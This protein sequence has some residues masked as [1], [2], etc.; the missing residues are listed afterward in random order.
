MKEK[1]KNLDRGIL[2]MLLASLSFAAMGGFA[3]VVSQTLPPVEVT[4]FRN[5][6]GVVLV[7]YSIYHIPL[8]QKGGRPLLLLFRGSMGFAALLAYFYIMAYIPLGEAVTYNK[9]SP[10]FVAIFAYL[11]LGEKLHKS[12]LL[13]IA[14]GF[15]GIVLIAQPEGGSFDKYDML[16]IFSGIGAALAYTSIRELREYY[17]TRTIVLSFMG[18]G[19]I[20]P[21]ILMLVTP[22]VT[23]PE[24]LDWMFAP[25]VWPV[26]IE[27]VYVS[28]VGVF[29][30][31]SQLLMTKAYEL[32]KAG[33]VGTISYTNI[34]FALIIG[35]LLGDPIPD[36][37]TFLGIIFVIVSG[38]I[39][40]LVK[41]K[42]EG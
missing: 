6:F 33:I 36:F 26:G 20:A 13:A 23:V 25:F 30:T 5:I 31:A 28:A 16:G 19:S 32:T 1:I 40:A 12:A 11:F 38:L 24:G 35:I 27:W 34:V 10:I 42:K 8:K 29:A 21:L 4:F 22:Y 41:E 37:W 7:G 39:V 17:D 3:K 9:T 18:V 2:F 14:I 15:A